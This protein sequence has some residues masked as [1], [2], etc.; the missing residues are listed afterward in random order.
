MTFN[1]TV[2]NVPPTVIG[3][4]YGAGLNNPL[5]VGASVGALLGSS[6]P[7]GEVAQRGARPSSG[8]WVRIAQQR[9]LVHVHS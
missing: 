6:D 5:I 8:S 9:W 2:N 7:G 1:W 3:H 4:S